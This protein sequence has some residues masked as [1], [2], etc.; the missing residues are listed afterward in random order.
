MILY[1]GF[2]AAR[3]IEKLQLQLPEAENPTQKE[4]LVLSWL[5]RVLKE[6]PGVKYW[7]MLQG[8]TDGELKA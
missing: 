6:K 1:E 4:H 7:A 2:N 8:L 5:K 3:G